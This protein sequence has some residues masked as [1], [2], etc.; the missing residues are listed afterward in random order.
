MA[1]QGPLGLRIP[2]QTQP[3][4]DSFLLRPEKTRSWIA[5]LPLANLGETSRRVYKAFVEFNR[6]TLSADTRAQVLR[7]FREPIAYVEKNLRRHY[8]G[9]S[10]PLTRKSRKIALLN[11]ELHAEMAISQKILIGGMFADKA[12]QLDRESLDHAIQQALGHLRN[13]LL[14]S[15]LAYEPCPRH[16]WRE[17]HRLA[18]YGLPNSAYVS[19]PGQSDGQDFNGIHETYTRILLLAL[20]GPYKLR[21][22][23]ILS[24]NEGVDEWSRHTRLLDPSEFRKPEDVTGL[25][26]ADLASD[27]P[28][29]HLSLGSIPQH[30]QWVVLNTKGLIEH[31]RDKLDT[32][33]ASTS[34]R[35]DLNAAPMQKLLQIWSGAPA[36]RHPRT[37]LNFQLKIAV[38]L[39]AIWGLLSADGKDK[40]P[41]AP[42][43]HS[44][45]IKKPSD[46]DWLE[47]TDMLQHTLKSGF[48]KTGDDEALSLTPLDDDPWQGNTRGPIAPIVDTRPQQDT[49]DV[50][51]SHDRSSFETRV[52][53]TFDESASGY[54]VN[55]TGEN[56][57]HV[58]IGE[59]I[60]IQS[61]AHEKQYDLATVRWMQNTP[62]DGLKLG[63]ELLA[64]TVQA[65]EVS[66]EQDKLKQSQ[67]CLLLPERKASSS[68]PS[69]MCPP[70]RFQVGETARLKDGDKESRIRFTRR[71]EETGAFSQFLF[72]P[73]DKEKKQGP[74]DSDFDSI[75]SEL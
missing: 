48:L 69:L 31:V 8:I 74:S 41:E 66:R 21:Q 63:M 32:R 12:G 5:D 28:P 26:L 64:R 13:T 9:A 62:K 30:K 18:A 52:F 50:W 7:E 33:D 17:I 72:A 61:P 43:P 44:G 47:Q 40:E 36:R 29:Q 58:T 55:W 11:R 19:Q 3:S 49:L 56:I 65:V 51:S 27:G 71:L 70:L 68:P 37:N 59:L 54:G 23:E 35:G 10:F 16:T 38:G 53:R 57:P 15:Y 20:S 46:R 6:I 34:G 73:V 1:A 4:A 14:H 25:F 39:N 2:E 45:A 42:T 22:R 67:H 24:V 75:W 60:G